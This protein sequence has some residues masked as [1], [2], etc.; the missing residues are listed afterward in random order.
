MILSVM[1]FLTAVGVVVAGAAWCADHGLQRLG[2]P[3]RFVWAGALLAGPV[4][5]AVGLVPAAAPAMAGVAGSLPP[6]VIDLPGLVI[7]EPGPGLGL[8]GYVAAAVWLVS[9]LVFLALLLRARGLLVR[10]AATWRAERVLGRD[11]LVADRIGPAVAGTVRPRIVLPDWVLALPERQLSM[12]LAHEEEHVR[13]GDARLLGVALAIV[14]AAAWHP[15]NWWMFRRLRSAIEIDCD[16][17]V[18][19]READPMTYGESLLAVA[20]RASRPPLAIAAFTESSHSLERRILAMTSR[21]TSGTRIT[22]ALLLAV[23]ALVGV[24]A[25]GV[26]SPVD[27]GA[28]D[29]G[30]PNTAE[31]PAA[32]AAEPTFTP[33]TVAPEIQNRDEV[34]AAM[35]RSYPPLLRDAGI[36]GAVRVYFL[37]SDTG[38]VVETRID[39]SSGHEALDQAALAV[40]G[41]YRFA[42]A[43]NRDDAV[44]VW[45]SF[46]IT[47][48][49]DA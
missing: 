4:M 12:V 23:A 9:T 11:V 44:P 20:A 24:Q 5:L 1:I 33:F 31:V 32:I 7:G 21:A 6:A 37:I 48:R 49:P 2:L 47:F 41:V 34:I 35:A 19:R 30:A 38:R 14:T 25:C 45:V 42:P 15:V 10:D 39:Q 29:D 18:L 16:R 13:A 28:G 8:V 46:P 36:G 27:Y 22:G 3:S 43:L 40:A 26:D 17:R